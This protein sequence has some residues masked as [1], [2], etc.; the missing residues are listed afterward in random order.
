[1]TTVSLGVGVWFLGGSHV[2]KH[3]EFELWLTALGANTIIFT[4]IDTY[5]ICVESSVRDAFN[6]GYDVTLVSDCVASRNSMHHQTTLDQVGEAFGLVVSSDEL[7]R[8]METKD[9]E[10]SP[11]PGRVWPGEARE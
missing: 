10:L 4:G 8:L 2:S 7:I 1:M 11:V 3:T 6:R 9:L 5:Y